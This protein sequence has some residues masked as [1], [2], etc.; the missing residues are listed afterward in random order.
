MYMFEYVDALHAR[1]GFRICY[2]SRKLQMIHVCVCIHTC[3]FIKKG[4][5]GQEVA[6]STSMCM[7]TYMAT[8]K[9]AVYNMEIVCM[10]T[11]ILCMHISI[12]CMHAYRYDMY[13]CMK[14]YCACMHTGMICMH[15]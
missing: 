12:L 5:Q 6:E 14:V 11:G 3:V 13:V 2:K 15:A 4:L 9:K 1:L 7:H 8:H 10:H